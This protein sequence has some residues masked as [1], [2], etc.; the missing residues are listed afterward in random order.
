M[1]LQ[2]LLCLSLSLRPSQMQD[3]SA[4]FT[5]TRVLAF[6]SSVTCFS[7]ADHCIPQIFA[8]HSRR[9]HARRARSSFSNHPSHDIDSKEESRCPQ[10]L[11]S[12]CGKERLPGRGAEVEHIGASPV[13]TGV[14][15]FFERLTTCRYG[16]NVSNVRNV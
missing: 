2:P 7:E 10:W 12:K 16:P 8:S 13:G 11:C 9:R 6:D 5:T 4:L 1:H 15:L 3:Y 14:E